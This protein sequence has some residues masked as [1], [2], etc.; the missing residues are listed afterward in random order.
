M[1]SYQ[2]IGIHATSDKAIAAAAALFAH[3]PQEQDD[4]REEADERTF[5][6][7]LNLHDEASELGDWSSLDDIEV[8]LRTRRLDASVALHR[9]FLDAIDTIGTLPWVEAGK[10]TNCEVLWY[11]QEALN[12]DAAPKTAAMLVCDANYRH[13]VM[14][15]LAREYVKEHGEELLVAGWSAS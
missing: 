6:Q 3:S 11:L 1:N 15:S 10:L 9:V 8:E 2:P 7:L 4:Q 14:C 12:N 13:E 5:A